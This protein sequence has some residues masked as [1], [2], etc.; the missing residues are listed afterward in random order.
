MVEESSLEFRLRKSVE[1]RNYLLD[2]IKHNELISEN[3]EKT[4]KYLSDAEYLLILVSIVTACAWISA[5]GSLVC[6]PVGVASFEVGLKICAVTA[7]IIN[8]KSIIKKEKKS[9]IK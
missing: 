8:Y 1:K 2:E 5:F 7:G 6:V 9:M 4:C 3:Y